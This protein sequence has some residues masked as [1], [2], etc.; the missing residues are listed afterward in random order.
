MSTGESIPAASIAGASAIPVEQAIHSS[1]PE[2][3]VA[4]A[5][6]AGLTEDLAL[7]LLKRNDLLPPV[8]EALGENGSAGIRNSRSIRRALAQHPK[9][10]RHVSLPLLRLLFTFDL[11]EVTLA[12]GTPPDIKRASEEALMNRLEGISTGEKI[13]LARRGSA[14]I[15]G[16]LLMDS[17]PR[18]MQT[19]IDNARL[20]EAG[21]IKAVRNSGASAAFIHA[22]CNHAKWSLRR[23]VRLALLRNEHTPL[24]YAVTY[25]RSFPPPVVREVLQASSL[26]GN[27][28]S[29]LLAT[30][31]A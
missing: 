8:F 5:A 12:P 20:T 4:A 21:V 28:K 6:D 24:A 3:L 31:S 18:V 19:A 26:P 14:R 29:H 2:I 7:T 10:P 13:S 23:E 1:S 17:G 16:A 11:M 30:L 9:T 25:V 15:A 22:V 27:I